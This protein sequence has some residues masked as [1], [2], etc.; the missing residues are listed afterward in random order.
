MPDEAQQV[1]ALVHPDARQL[2]RADVL[3]VV[4]VRMPVLEPCCPQEVKDWVD[5]AFKIGH[6][7][8]IYMG[9]LMTVSTA[10]G[11]EL[12]RISVTK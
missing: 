5:L 9:Y 11:E 10:D 3:E 8:S 7:G 1:D 4:A 2:Q 6:A 12:S